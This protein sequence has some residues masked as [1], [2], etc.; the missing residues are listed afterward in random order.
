MTV[1]ITPGPI[2]SP[3]GENPN[4]YCECGS[5]SDVHRS[6]VFCHS[7]RDIE[8]APTTAGAHA[9]WQPV[10]VGGDGPKIPGDEGPDRVGYWLNGAATVQVYEGPDTGQWTPCFSYTVIREGKQYFMWVCR[11]SH[12]ENPCDEDFMREIST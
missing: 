3:G 8:Y 2:P 12:V 11:R 7:P 10:I 6:Y 1:T 9:E 5:L 4:D